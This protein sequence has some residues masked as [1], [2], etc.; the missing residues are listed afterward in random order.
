MKPILISRIPREILPELE[1]RKYIVDSFALHDFLITLVT[2]GF[3]P[4]D[5]LNRFHRFAEIA[6][7]F[8]FESH[9]RLESVL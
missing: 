2:I 3:L 8:P 4:N 7:C 1:V 9:H 5:V 6:F